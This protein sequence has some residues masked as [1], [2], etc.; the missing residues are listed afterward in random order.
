[1]AHISVSLDGTT[2][3][4]MLGDVPHG[5]TI[6]YNHKDETTTFTW[7]TNGLKDGPVIEQFLTNN[8]L[9]NYRYDYSYRI[10]SE[11]VVS[12][13]ISL[14]NWTRDR[15]DYYPEDEAAEE[16]GE[17]LY[18]LLSYAEDDPT[19]H[20]GAMLVWKLSQGMTDYPITQKDRQGNL[21]TTNWSPC[22]RPN[23]VPT[24][25]HAGGCYRPIYAMAKDP[26]NSRDTNLTVDIP[27][28]ED[29]Y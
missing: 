11:G 4:Q 2:I 25:S 14:E 8:T 24:V 28:I 19:L 21:S 12:S 1:M 5:L 17:H 23:L 15:D 20:L 7:Y 13:E 10:W 3:R 29:V 26:W 9:G 16:A 6:S 18:E 27:I 22:E